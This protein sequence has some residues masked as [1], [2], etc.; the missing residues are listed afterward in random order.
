MLFWPWLAGAAQLDAVRHHLLNETFESKNDH[1]RYC[2]PANGCTDGSHVH[3]PSWLRCAALV[4][5]HRRG[6]NVR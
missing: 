1:R 6:P 3:L 4:C 5:C 2:V